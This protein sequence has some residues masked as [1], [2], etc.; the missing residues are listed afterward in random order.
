MILHEIA[1]GLQQLYRIDPIPPLES[2]L[3]SSEV[4]R[5]YCRSHTDH[6]PAVRET[7]LIEQREDACE[8]GL[9]IAPDILQHLAVDNPR[10][11]LHA[12]NLDAA[13]VAIE[14]V[15]HLTYVWWKFH[16]EV[17]C[18]LLELELQAEIDKYLLC[19][20]WLR[21]Q[22]RQEPALMAQLFHRYTLCG[23]MSA[24]AAERYQRASVLAWRFCHGHAGPRLLTHARDFYRLTHW[25]K[26]RT[27]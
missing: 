12:D 6:D 4:Y 26:L 27:L 15:S 7:L 10:V 25:Q 18:S 2:C 5:A 23:G 22:G 14:G 8:I 9:Y 24:P 13:C 11:C 19:A 16:R 3:I 17:P 20:Q 1:S 21:A